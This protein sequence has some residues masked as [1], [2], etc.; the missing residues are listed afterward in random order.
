MDITET[1]IER[2][3]RYGDYGSQS[4]T[5]QLIKAAMAQGPNWLTLPA[6][7]KEALELIATKIARALHGDPDYI[8][9]WHDIAGYAK[10]VT[11]YLDKT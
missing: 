3:S 4:N 5:A 8:D 2:G 9:N 7:H 1:L 11:D 10:L 6:P